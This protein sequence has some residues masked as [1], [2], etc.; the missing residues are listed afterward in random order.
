LAIFSFLASKC[1]FFSERPPPSSFLPQ[2]MLDVFKVFFFPL[3]LSSLFQ[4]LKEDILPLASGSLAHRV[5]PPN[6]KRFSPPIVVL[7]MD[8]SSLAAVVF[9]PSSIPRTG[10]NNPFLPDPLHILPARFFFFFQP[11]FGSPQ[12]DAIRPFIQLSFLFPAEGS[13]CLWL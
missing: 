2:V 5:P 8:P 7:S 1:P 11:A 6:L 4:F 3:L 13:F 12:F 9:P 10:D